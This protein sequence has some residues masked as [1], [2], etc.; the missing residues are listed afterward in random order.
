MKPPRR[1]T[2]NERQRNIA[3]AAAALL[4]TLCAASL[5]LANNS[6][7]T[8][9]QFRQARLNGAGSG[10]SGGGALAGHGA[11]EG[12]DDLT[13]GSIL[14]VPSQ[15]NVCRLRLIDNRTWTMRD[16]GSVVCD[17]A[18]S[19]NAAVR[20]HHSPASRIEAIRSG[21]SGR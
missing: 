12:D 4:V 1:R 16:A 7:T 20:E 5:Y 6:L 17:D 13:T 9:E 8:S 19:W 3:L 21:F 2:G 10:A 15:G 18:V 11:A 14:F